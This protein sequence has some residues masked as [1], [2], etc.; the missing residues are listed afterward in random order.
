MNKLLGMPRY[1]ESLVTTAFGQFNRLDIVVNN[2][3]YQR[4]HASV[5]EIWSRTLDHEINR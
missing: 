4:T 3:A 2:A 5:D 1:A